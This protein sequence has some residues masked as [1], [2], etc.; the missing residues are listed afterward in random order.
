MSDMDPGEQLLRDIFESDEAR[1]EREAAE[2]IVRGERLRRALTEAPGLAEHLRT[3]VLHSDGRTEAG[4]LR[5]WRTPL[6]TGTTDDADELF[7]VL[8][9]HVTFWAEQLGIKP[10][11]TAKAWNT[12]G[13][14]RREVE[15]VAAGFRAGTTPEQASSLVWAL[16]FWLL[17]HDA[18]IAAHPNAATYQDEVASLV[19]SLRAGS[20]LASAPV[21]MASPRPCPICDEHAVHGE[22]FGST[23]EAAEKRGER[24]SAYAR[25]GDETP[26]QAL[27][28]FLAAVAGVEVRCD[29]CGWKADAKATQIARWLA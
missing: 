3:I 14:I 10:P 7:V 19:W 23:F 12:R 6:L 8:L 25:A 22:F 20:R 2:A 13:G 4:D 21:R 16:A 15:D 28:A 5:E 26:E 1:A 18:A 17:E 24:L 27:N 11:L 9:E 29:F